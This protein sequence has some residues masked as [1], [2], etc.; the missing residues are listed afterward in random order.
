MSDDLAPI[1]ER[2]GAATP[3]PWFW[4][5]YSG[6]FAGGPEINPRSYDEWWDA[7]EAAG[8]TDADFEKGG[9]LY[10]EDYRRD[11]LV[12]HVP[13]IAGDT[14][15]GR[16]AADADFIANAPADVAYLLAEVDRLRDLA[17]ALAFPVEDTP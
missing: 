10:A 9:R 14:A 12:A 7:Q 2:L 11:P 15:T 3:G 1:R 4:N 5:S 8:A 16:H 6:V 13:A 17:S